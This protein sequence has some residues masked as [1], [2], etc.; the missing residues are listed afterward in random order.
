MKLSII[1]INYNNAT[2][3]EC[4]IKSV[5]SNKTTEVEYIVIDGGSVDTSVDII[6]RYQDGIDK[7]IS[8]QDKG[9]YNAMNKGIQMAS[10]EY[11]MFVNSGDNLYEDVD[12]NKILAQINGEDIIYHDLEIMGEGEWYIKEYPEQLDFKYF[13]EDSIPHLG[14]LIKRELFDKYGLYNESF[15]IVSDWAFFMDCILLH[16]CSYKHINNCF[17]IFYTDGIS[18]DPMN[19]QKLIDERDSHIANSYPPYN[20]LYQD[21]KSKREELYK[22]KTSKSVTYLKKVGFLKWLNIE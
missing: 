8:E 15:K 5:I 10:G 2:D 7:W 19:F 17:A 18:S 16:N 20:S 21:W 11:L 4:T 13:A 12:F 1:T 6:H 22:L 3:L 14:T 9:I